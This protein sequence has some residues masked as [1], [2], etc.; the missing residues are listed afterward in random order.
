MRVLGQQV[1]KMQIKKIMVFLGRVETLLASALCAVGIALAVIGIGW[2]CV[3][4][5]G[6]GVSDLILGWL[7]VSWGKGNELS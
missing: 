7:A 3:G 4:E 6:H 2:I 5:L 1:E